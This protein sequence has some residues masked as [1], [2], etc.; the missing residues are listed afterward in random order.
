MSGCVCACI[1]DIIPMIRRVTFAALI[2]AACGGGTA[3]ARAD[4]IWSAGDI[5]TSPNWSDNLNW[6]GSL[7]PV[8]SD[9]VTFPNV[10]GYTNTFGV[11]N[12]IVDANTTIAGLVYNSTNTSSA[13][14][15]SMFFTTLIPGGSSL[16]IIGSTAA[17]VLTVGNASILTS[18]SVNRTNYTYILGSGPL[19]VSN[20]SGSINIWQRGSPSYYGATLDLSGLASFNASVS[21]VMVGATPTSGFANDSYVSGKLMLATNNSIITT[22]N[23]VAPGILLGRS[24]AGTSANVNGG[25]NVVLGAANAFNTDGLVIG[26]NRGYA[27]SQLAFAAGSTGNTFTLRGSAGGSVPAAVF[28]IADA[29]AREDGYAGT[30]YGTGTVNGTA[31]FTGG[32]V[33]ILADR[34]YVGRSTPTSINSG[35][36]SAVGNLIFESGTISATNLYVGYYQGSIAATYA[37]GNVTLNSNA[38]LNVSKD[39]LL[40]HGDSANGFFSTIYTAG[41][42]NVNTG[43]VLNVSGNITNDLF[44][45]VLNLGG[46]KVDLKPAGDAT[47]GSVSLTDLAGF[48]VITNASTITVSSSLTPGVV[49]TSGALYLGGNFAMT[50]GNI[51]WDIGTNSTING[52]G[53]D[54]ARITG[55]TISFSNP[56]LYLNYASALVP[57]ATYTLM[58]FPNAISVSGSIYTE[59]PRYAPVSLTATGVVMKV[60]ASLV[61]GRDIWRGNLSSS[62]DNSLLNTNWLYNGSPSRFYPGDD[63]VIDDTALATNV[64]ATAVVAP[65]SLTFSNATKTITLGDQNISGNPAINIAGGFYKNG[66]GLVLLTNNYTMN[67]GGPININA[68]TLRI[69]RNNANLFGSSANTNPITV[70]AGA[71]LDFGTAFTF[72]NNTANTLRPWVVGG[73]GV[74]NQGALLRSGAA[75][76]TIYTP[77]MTLSAD[78]RMNAFTNLNTSSFYVI[79]GTNYSIGANSELGGTLNLAGHSLEKVGPGRMSLERMTTT[80]GNILVSQGVLNVGSAHI[81]GSGT[82]TLASGTGLSFS[83]PNSNSTNEVS[84][85]VV[86]N[87]GGAWIFYSANGGQDLLFNGPVTLNGSLTVSNGFGHIIHLIGVVS[88]SGGIAKYFPAVLSFEAANTYTGETD[89]NGGSAVLTAGGSLASTNIVINAG[90]IFDVSA[91]SGGYTL[92][93]GQILTLAG[94][95]IMA[96]GDIIIASG[97]SCIS[98]GTNLGN[99]TVNSGGK[100]G[101]GSAIG[102]GTLTVASNLSLTGASVTFN[103]GS[104]TN[105]GG[106]DNDLIQSADLTLAGTSTITIVPLGSLV[107]APGAKYTLFKYTGTGPVNTN[108]LIVTSVNPR[109]S[110]VASVDTVNKLVQVQASGDSSPVIWRGMAASSPTNWDVGI[111]TN[112]W[113]S[114]SPNLFYSGDTVF[115][116]NTG[117][118]NTVSMIGTLLPGSVIVSNNA[119]GYTFN[120][121]GSLQGGKLVIDATSTGGATL[122]NSANNVLNG[123]GIT[124]NSGRTLTVNQPVNASI[125]GTLNGSGTINKTGTNVLT[126]I[127]SSTG[128]SGTNLVSAGTLKPGSV[129]ALGST[130]A[131]V[132]VAGGTLDLAGYTVDTAMV[133]VSGSGFGAAGAVVNSGSDIV[134]SNALV[135]VVLTNATTLGGSGNYQIGRWHLDPVSLDYFPA[136][137]ISEGSYFNGQS[138]SLTKLGAGD[139]RINIRD[140]T[141]LADINVGAG[142]LIFNNPSV[143][144]TTV[145]TLGHPEN[146]ITV[147]NGATLGLRGF[148]GQV[149]AGPDGTYALSGINSGTKPINQQKFFRIKMKSFQHLPSRLQF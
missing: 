75:G 132:K 114:G 45:A 77:K 97:A 146:T 64:L 101:M 61:G 103:L 65:N 35:R 102:V 69:V 106:A 119:T 26:G 94:T 22:P 56:H 82:L 93:S 144:S 149:T 98:S 145:A 85:T 63:V 29:T 96:Q 120:G 37:Q 90:C 48:G 70:A 81:D 28:N 137:G 34:M 116:D 8:P 24:E 105:I 31:D 80:A 136:Q 21:N 50:G 124:V 148:K 83:S 9:I 125:T 84:K 59:T 43:A 100:L 52:G 30:G 1:R 138:N 33:N 111:T 122:A 76:V 68:G 142:R 121:T 13:A 88:G 57:N 32:T 47:S 143:T 129:G 123:T 18:P 41:T 95:T 87:S 60:G 23:L 17:S 49:G 38:V 135:G 4:A 11:V 91:K 147:S 15:N 113:V 139:V 27:G 40:G 55:S 118:T 128:F 126:L 104:T 62:W 20:R 115:F 71:T 10:A 92:N 131:T 73:T 44:K 79:S 42:L 86:V 141:F 54:Y 46:G 108:N 78:T 5:G 109:L 7:S 14:G 25:G 19:N 99:L 72:Y 110:F 16:S 112:W 66:S 89:I 58:Q 67:I 51:Y 53:N 3:T 2:V 107:V 130:T 127:G 74:F 36:G 12:N 39:V 117:L 134:M 140:E 133:I 6:S